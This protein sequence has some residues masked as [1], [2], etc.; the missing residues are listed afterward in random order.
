[1]PVAPHESKSANYGHPFRD[2]SDI[3][4]FACSVVGWGCTAGQLA[5][6][7][8]CRQGGAA[9]VKYTHAFFDGCHGSNPPWTPVHHP[10]HRNAADWWDPARE[11]LKTSVL[12]ENT[13]VSHGN[14]GLTAPCCTLCM[15]GRVPPL[16]HP[17]THPATH[18]QQQVYLNIC[19]HSRSPKTSSAIAY[20]SEWPT[21]C[22]APCT[23]QFC[24]ACGAPLPC[25]LPPALPHPTPHRGHINHMQ[26]PCVLITHYHGETTHPHWS[27]FHTN[28]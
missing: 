3:Q 10:Y 16:H 18:L 9:Q 2:C 17:P 28:T 23:T 20:C 22:L 27:T 13:Y 14:G 6:Q 19:R 8:L 15:G 4:R 24:K 1:L 7:I 21:S 12:H 25:V 26:P 11:L 5:L